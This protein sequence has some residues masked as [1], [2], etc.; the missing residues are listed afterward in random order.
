V[1]ERDVTARE[2]RKEEKRH[3]LLLSMFILPYFLFR[4]AR[5]GLPAGPSVLVAAMACEESKDLGGSANGGSS[6]ATSDVLLRPIPARADCTVDSLTGSV[7]VLMGESDPET[8]D[9]C[10]DDIP[11]SVTLL[12]SVTPT[13]L[14]CVSVNADKNDSKSKS[15]GVCGGGI[16]SEVGSGGCGCMKGGEGI[17]GGSERCGIKAHVLDQGVDIGL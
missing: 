9:R 10:T 17:G 8:V 4:F 7:S 3:E 1:Q 13:S 11:S 15:A 14:S 6:P 5:G 12:M 2:K 16:P